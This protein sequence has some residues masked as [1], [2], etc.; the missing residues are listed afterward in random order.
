MARKAANQVAGSAFSF[1]SN[2]A[3][4]HLAEQYHQGGQQLDA[5]SS[6]TLFET[7]KSKATALHSNHLSEI[8]AKARSITPS[9]IL[10]MVSGQGPL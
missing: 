9:S 3:L 8:H 10:Q 5:N 1:C 4:D 6:Q 2:F 7:L